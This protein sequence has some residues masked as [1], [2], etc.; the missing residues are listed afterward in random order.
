MR[1]VLHPRAFVL[2][3]AVTTLSA[4]AAGWARGGEPASGPPAR[5]QSQGETPKP[6]VPAAAIM[7]PEELAR[8]LG[9]RTSEKPLIFHV[10]FRFLYKEGHIPGSEYVGPGSKEDGLALLRRRVASLD[11]T[12][13]IVLYCGCCPW[14]RCPNVKPAYDALRDMG[15]KQV[16]VLRINDNFGTNWV[17]KGYPTARGE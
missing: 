5:T 7:E 16:K 15:F 12:K 11:R 1:I 14:M 17:A 2:A 3:I 8:I 6:P 4:L 9:S 10:G 13:F